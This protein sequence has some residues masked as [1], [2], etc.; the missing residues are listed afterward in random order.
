MYCMQGAKI[1]LFS[2][3]KGHACT[4]C[5]ILLPNDNDSYSINMYQGPGHYNSRTVVD[6]WHKPTHNVTIAT[7]MELAR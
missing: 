1:F 6:S 3:I 4:Y 7:E 2:V 5:K